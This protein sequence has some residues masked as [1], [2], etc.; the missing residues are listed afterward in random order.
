MFF[1]FG[2]P[3]SDMSRSP[4]VVPVHTLWKKY[5]LL[6]CITTPASVIPVLVGGADLM[7]PGVVQI[8]SSETV[9]PPQLVAIAQYITDSPITRGP[10]LAVGHL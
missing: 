8:P 5:V 6:L 9:V 7:I 2:Y 3:A 4:N 10:P 1:V